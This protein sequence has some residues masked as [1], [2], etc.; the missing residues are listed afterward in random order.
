MHRSDATAALR[1]LEDTDGVFLVKRACD[2][3][4]RNFAS[5]RHHVACVLETETA[6]YG[7][8]HLDSD[9]MDICAEPV[10]ISQALIQGDTALR[11]IVS[12]HW[13]GDS[14]SDPTVVPPC[15]NCRHLLLRYAPTVDVVVAARRG[16]IK[17]MKAS[18]L[19][20]MAYVKP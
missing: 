8:L 14:R 10:A 7:G 3:I 20:P 13:D 1:K 5:G 19:L 2:L 11:R 18:E 4:R 15:G 16:D 9:G 17:V 12:V 6:F